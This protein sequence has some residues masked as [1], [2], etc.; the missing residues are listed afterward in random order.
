MLT[1]WC[2]YAAS[3]IFVPY[4]LTCQGKAYR[5]KLWHCFYRKQ[6]YTGSRP[7]SVERPNYNRARPQNI[8]GH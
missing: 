1:S 2:G 6:G 4:L 5:L 8:S 7:G 3:T